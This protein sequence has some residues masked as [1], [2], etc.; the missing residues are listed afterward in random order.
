ML[1][2]SLKY[3]GGC[4]PAYDRA[5]LAETIRSRLNGQVKFVQAADG[6]DADVMLVLAG[7]E[8]ACADLSAFDRCETIMIRS[9]GEVAGRIADLEQRITEGGQGKEGPSSS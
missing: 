9:A 2:V 3:C 5:A 7:C 1:R 6:N 4:N 8:T